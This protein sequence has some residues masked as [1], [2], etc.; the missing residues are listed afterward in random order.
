MKFVRKNGAQGA[1]QGAQHVA[2]GSTP[3]THA[4]QQ[5]PQH[6]RGP[7]IALLPHPHVH[8]QTLHNISTMQ[9]TVSIM[10]ANTFP[11]RQLLKL[12]RQGARM[13]S[14]LRQI[15]DQHTHDEVEVVLSEQCV[16]PTRRTL[17]MWA[18]VTC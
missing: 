2:Y 18:S 14:D 3:T 7:L 1:D 15:L 6:P 12:I 8:Q 13:D 11:F 17:L 9:H 16:S 10:P 5:H 4:T